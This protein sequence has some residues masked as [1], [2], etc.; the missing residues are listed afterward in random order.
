[1]KKKSN[2]EGRGIKAAVKGFGREDDQLDLWEV[3]K[4]RAQVL[5]DPGKLDAMN[6]RLL[7]RE[8]A[9]QKKRAKK[10]G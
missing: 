4:A 3:L 10:K 1:A 2:K 5:E 6:K 8:A 9:A 7:R